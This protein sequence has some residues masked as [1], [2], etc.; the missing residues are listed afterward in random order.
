MLATVYSRF[1]PS[2]DTHTHARVVAQVAM[3]RATDLVEPPAKVAEI[4]RTRSQRDRKLRKFRREHGAKLACRS[5]FVAPFVISVVLALVLLSSFVVHRRT[6]IERY[7]AAK[8]HQA[9]CD[10]YDFNAAVNRTV[11]AN[12]T[13][14]GIHEK[15]GKCE[16]SFRYLKEHGLDGDHSEFHL[17]QD[18]LNDTLWWL[19]PSAWVDY[20]C[21]GRCKLIL[22][23]TGDAYSL[24]AMPI[25][26]M[27]FILSV[28]CIYF[29]I[30][31][32]LD[33]CKLRAQHELLTH[34]L[35]T[36]EQQVVWGAKDPQQAFAIGQAVVDA[37]QLE[38]AAKPLP[39][40]ATP[41]PRPPPQPTGSFTLADRLSTAKGDDKKRE[42][43]KKT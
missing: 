28:C 27:T 15:V 9:L 21:T 18:A 38:H 6:H 43:V 37:I 29:C 35:A 36:Q 41:P 33:Y 14:D 10:T 3:M 31:P 25:I 20:T 24:Y 8:A 30:R 1:G 32:L 2:V 7:E 34:Q 13:Y 22:Q 23:A 16:D 4:A 5:C 40:L 12:M 42:K 17:F 19:R 26:S 39:P 11:R